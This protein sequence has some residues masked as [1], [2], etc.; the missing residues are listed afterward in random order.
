MKTLFKT[1]FLVILLANSAYIPAAPIKF[2]RLTTKD[3]LSHNGIWGIAKDSY[4]FMWFGTMDGLNRYDGHTV[5]VFRH[6]PDDPH[7][8]SNDSTRM[9]YVDHNDVLWVGTWGKG[10]NKFDQETEQFIRYQYD[11]NDPH[12]LNHNAIRTLYEDRS[13]TLWVGTMKGL[14][15][16]DRQ[17]QQFT[18]YLHEPDNPNSLGNNF[19]KAIYEDRT[20]RFWIGT[21]NGLEQFDLT[22]EQFIQYQHDPADPYSLSNNNIQYLFEDSIGIFWVGTKQGLNIFDRDTKKFIRYQHDPNDPTSLSNNSIFTIQEE[23]NGIL[24]IGTWGGLNQFDRKTQTFTNYKNNSADPYSLSNNSIT[25]LHNDQAGIFW[26]GTINGINILDRGG[27]LF[28]HYRPIPNEPNNLSHHAVRAIYEDRAGILWIGTNGG[29]L[30]KFNNLTKQFTHYQHDPNNPNNLKNNSIITIYED[31]MGVLWLGGFLSGL[32]KFERDTEKFT[33]YYADNSHPL[34]NIDVFAIHEDQANNLWVATWD[35]GLNKFDRETEEFTSYLHDSTK[36]DSLSNNQVTSIYEDQAGRL[37]IGTMEGLNRFEPETGVFTSYYH[38]SA[39]PNSLGHNTVMSMYEDRKGQFWICMMGGGLDKFDREYEQFTHY[40]VKNGLPSNTVWGVLEE[41]VSPDKENLWLST[42]YGLSRFDPQTES[43]RNYDVTDGLQSNTFFAGNSYQKTHNGELFFGGSNGFNAFYP[44]QIKDNS[45]IPPIVI[46]DFQLAN[47]PVPIGGKSV[48]QK[49]ILVTKQLTLS[50]LD[51]VFSFEFAALNYRASEKNR[52]RYKM[53]GFEDEWN[54][55]DS[56]RRFVTYTNLDSGK[57]IFKVLGS[58]NDGFWNEEGTSIKITITPPWWETIWFRSSMLLLIIGLIIG[59]FQWRIRN[60]QKQKYH[61]EIQVANRTSELEIAKQ[62]AETANQAKSTFL[63]SMSHEL[64]TPLNGILGY[65]QILQRD[66]SITTRE[67]H[68]LNVIE[69]SGNHLLNLINDVLDLAKIESNKIELYETDFHLNSLLSDVSEIIKV[70]AK[71]KNIEFYLEFATNLPKN[72]HGDERRLRQILLNLLGNAVKFTD[73]GSVTLQVKAQPNLL[74]RIED[75]G[76]GISPQHF[77]HIFKPFKQVGEQERQAK[78]TGLGLAVSKN[79]V[80]LMGGQLSVSSEINLGTKFWFELNLPVV[81][82]HIVQ[83]ASQLPIVGIQGKSAKILIVD[84][85]LEN[86][87]VLVDLLAPLGFEIEL[88]QDGYEGLEKANQWLP[89]VII[90]DLIMPKMDGFELIRS[91]R[92]IPNLQKK[93]IIAVSASVYEEDKAKSLT[94][95]SDVFLPKPLQIKTLLEQLQHHLNLTWEYGEKSKAIEPDSQ[96]MVYPSAANMQDLY[97]LS[98]M[99]NV[100]EL[101]Q[102]VTTLA[103]SNI[104]LKPFATKIQTFLSQYKISELID[105]LEKADK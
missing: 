102:Q 96:P 53:E 24:W 2:D 22:T 47:K 39:N 34:S 31:R 10:L 104:K 105:W 26:V 66:L 98:L 11:P 45:T 30:N 65:A 23:P 99:G 87:A 84:D 100:K 71:Y 63:A 61:L 70:R 97:E 49:S 57:Y 85:N 4:G 94:V 92:K 82:Y 101:K 48:L 18:R 40:T 13:G 50:Y 7:S 55:V 32:S 27:K 69:R 37:W 28:H 43:F 78:G 67:L 75:T 88:A 17:T 21:N 25:L 103:E 76:I 38:D 9:L 90:T 3:G 33:H 74:F 5:K 8:L 80:E 60:I 77:E 73:K 86:Q 64:R 83:V 59:G 62:A 89:D 41:Y 91:L 1:I 68:G 72:V 46:T 54:E 35:G 44:N 81:D 51:R 12:S 36:P 42:T 52:Y 79:L 93:I 95:G 6:D 14:N 29:G 20:G 16:F 15:K 58:N 19:V 56:N